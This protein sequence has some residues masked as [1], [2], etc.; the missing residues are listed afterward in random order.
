MTTDFQFSQEL[1]TAEQAARDAGAAIM[2]LFRGKYDVHEKSKNNPVTTAD[3]EANR[4]IHERIAE[5][6]PNDGWL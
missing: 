5:T 6:F 4:I 3:L 1:G 2:A